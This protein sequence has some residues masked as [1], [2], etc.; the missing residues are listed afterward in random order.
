MLLRRLLPVAPATIAT[1]TTTTTGVP[2]RLAASVAPATMARSPP[3]PHASRALRRPPHR[4]PRPSPATI[5]DSMNA[6]PVLPESRIRELLLGASPSS[7]SPRFSPFTAARPASES[8][9]VASAGIGRPVA[10]GTSRRFQDAAVDA[11]VRRLTDL[12]ARLDTIIA[13]LPQLRPDDSISDDT[14]PA[15]VTGKLSAADAAVA[16]TVVDLDSLLGLL[17]ADPALAVLDLDHARA[18]FVLLRL[19][20]AGF[21]LDVKHYNLLLAHVLAPYIDG[22]PLGFEGRSNRTRSSNRAPSGQVPLAVLALSRDIL[23]HMRERGVAGDDATASLEIAAA[24]MEHDFARVERLAGAALRRH[25]QLAPWAAAAA[26]RTQSRLWREAASGAAAAVLDPHVYIARNLPV[27]THDPRCP[28]ASA[29]QSPP[30]CSTTLLWDLFGA[31]STAGNSRTVSGS[32]GSRRR[33]AVPPAAA[34]LPLFEAV[35]EAFAAAPVPQPKALARARQKLLSVP[36][37]LWRAH[38]FEVALGCVA[39]SGSE[40]EFQQLMSRFHQRGYP[41]TRRVVL[42]QMRFWLY[43]GNPT[44]VVKNYFKFFDGEPPASRRDNDDDLDDKTAGRRRAVFE[45][46]HQA[47][48]L[49]L[50][51]CRRLP[52]GAASPQLFPRR[53]AAALCRSSSR[54]SSSSSSNGAHEREGPAGA[55]AALVPAARIVDA[56]IEPSLRRMLLAAS[57]LVGPGTWDALLAHHAATAAAAGTADAVAA[58]A[59]AAAAARG[60]ALLLNHLVPAWRAAQ[61]YG[62]APLPPA[63]SPSPSPPLAQVPANATSTTTDADA[64]ADADA[65][66]AMAA[67]E[68][69]ASTPLVIGAGALPAAAECVASRRDAQ[70]LRAFCDRWLLAA[71]ARIAAAVPAEPFEDTYRA[72]LRGWLSSSSS[73]AVTGGGGAGVDEAAAAE[74]EAV[75]ADVRRRELELR[76]GPEEK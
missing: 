63:S 53:V 44:A 39:V 17:S 45:P 52:G 28:A 71:P 73:A 68:R 13:A 21:E 14:T 11:T 22:R 42:A 57:P 64:D 24:A 12:R 31:G 29:P 8:A 67:L 10:A 60:L 41:L 37:H 2:R 15:V 26:V 49:V 4:R 65:E 3:P 43:R 23:A 62:F 1:P 55:A 47:F 56:A 30:R 50:E 54:S 38:T 58:V 27:V 16:A 69:L 46:D 34:T 36:P 70:R 61:V 5:P 25:A 33:R 7:P 74:V 18:L 35:A 76:A 59:A 72:V 75:L 40:T 51:A 19:W 20:G 32:G 6:A 66:A 48:V 9:A